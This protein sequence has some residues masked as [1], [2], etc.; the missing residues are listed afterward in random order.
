[1]LNEYQNHVA[2]RAAEGLPPLP[3]NAEQV[4]S[5]VELLKQGKSA[6]SEL[7]LDLLINRVPPGVDQAAYVKAAFFDSNSKIRNNM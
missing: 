1:V 5:L 4:T 7:L 6:D 2:D 3:L